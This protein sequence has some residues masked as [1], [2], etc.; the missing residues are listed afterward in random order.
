MQIINTPYNYKNPNKYTLQMQ[1][2]TRAISF[3]VNPAKQ[4]NKTSKLYGALKNKIFSPT[5]QFVSKCYDSLTTVLAEKI[6]VPLAENDKIKNLATKLSES[7]NFYLNLS[8]IDSIVLSS[9][10]MYRTAKNDG[11]KKDQKLPLIVNQGLVTVASAAMTYALQNIISKNIEKYTN[12]FNT[13]L[14]KV[15]ANTED[16]DNQVGKMTYGVGKIQSVIIFG[17]IYRFIAPVFITPVANRLSEKIQNKNK[18]S[19][20]T[21]PVPTPGVIKT[22]A[23]TAISNIP[24]NKQPKIESY[25]KK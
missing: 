9:F 2:S 7:K 4:L 10:Y 3:G 6:F 18:Q 22:D 12:I 8:V 19:S 15:L 24:D 1:E 5:H 11:I 14:T 13:Q 23:K 21:A 16:C 25:L 20:S 17:I